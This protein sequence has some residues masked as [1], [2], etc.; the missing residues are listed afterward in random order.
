MQQALF[1]FADVIVEWKQ[2][3]LC[4]PNHPFSHPIKAKKYFPHTCFWRLCGAFSGWGMYNV[5]QSHVYMCDG[6]EVER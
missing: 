6:K 3:G 5:K 2:I 1:L 4:K